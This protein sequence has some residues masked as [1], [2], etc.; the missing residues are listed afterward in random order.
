[1]RKCPLRFDPFISSI[2]GITERDVA[3]QPRFDQIVPRLIA[4]F[5]DLRIIAHNATFDI[6]ALREAYTHCALPCPTLSYGC[7]LVWSRRLLDLP[8]NRLPIVCNHLGIPLNRHHDAGDDARA[9][10]EIATALA[11]RTARRLGNTSPTR[12]ECPIKTLRSGRLC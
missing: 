3:D 2:H 9:V 6:A 10:A 8:S 12:E 5:G 1:M 4:G 7:T 11:V